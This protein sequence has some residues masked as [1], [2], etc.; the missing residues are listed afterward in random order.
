M[1]LITS[2]VP[3]SPNTWVFGAWYGKK[4]SDNPKAVF[5]YVNNGNNAI[6]AI[7]ITKD[8]HLC[9]KLRQ[10]GINARN[11][12]SLYGMWYQ[13]RAGAAILTHSVQADFFSPCISG[14]TKRVH[15]WHGIPLKKIGYNGHF[16]RDARIKLWLKNTLFRFKRDHI[17]LVCAAS[18]KVA[19]IYSL[20]FN[21]PRSRTIVTG[22]PNSDQVILR[23]KENDNKEKLFILYAPTF[24]NG[25]WQEFNFFGPYISNIG[26]LDKK[27]EQENMRLG[28]RPHPVNKLTKTTIDSISASKNIYFEGADELNDEIWKYDAL[29]T[30]FSGV[31]FDF[32]LLKRPIYFLPLGLESYLVNERK[33]YV[34]YEQFTKGHTLDGWQDLEKNIP[35]ISNQLR[36]GAAPLNEQV[37]EYGVK[38]YDGRNSERVYQEILSLFQTPLQND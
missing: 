17:D 16:N 20:A 35:M 22:S 1:Y 6:D 11:A 15:L 23:A 18:D 31:M 8:K 32:A 33:L 5:D 27:L 3:K 14:K 7:W 9:K 2:M 28:I 34:D 21:V 10:G 26:V 29:I 30:D 12:T 13:M 37:A 4:Y 36:T 24:R 25:V 38:Y 19:D